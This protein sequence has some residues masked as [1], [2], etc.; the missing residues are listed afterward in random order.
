MLQILFF[1][2][3]CYAIFQKAWSTISRKSEAV[4]SGETP[5]SHGKH[6]KS[7]NHPSEQKQICSSACSIETKQN[8]QIALYKQATVHVTPKTDVSS[9]LTE[10]FE[11]EGDPN[12]L[13]AGLHTCGNLAPTCLQ[14]FV[15]N[16]NIH[17]ICNVGCCYHL[18]DEYF[19]NNSSKM[20]P[21]NFGFPMSQFLLD[22]KF[23][24]GRNAR[25]LSAQSM[26]RILTKEV[27]STFIDF[28]YE[29]IFFV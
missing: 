1:I 5:V 12:I 2:N 26:A 11:V 22:K 18:I 29:Y 27:V 8:E 20:S 16:K 23:S 15:N 6:W 17:S 24:L 3:I 13:L 28:V 21:E 25:M 7:K 19:S 10:H 4:Q 9:L 14:L